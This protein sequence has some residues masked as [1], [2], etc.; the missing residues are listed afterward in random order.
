MAGKFI[1]RTLIMITSVDWKRLGLAA[2]SR[3]D[4]EDWKL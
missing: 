4:E 1:E 3:T 2:G